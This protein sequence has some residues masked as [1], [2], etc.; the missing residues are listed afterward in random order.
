[1]SSYY[2]KYFSERQRNAGGN[3]NLD[4]IMLPR[5]PNGYRT[6]YEMFSDFYRLYLLTRPE[7]SG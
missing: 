4:F 1:L 3:E 5:S 6:A 7:V 2:E